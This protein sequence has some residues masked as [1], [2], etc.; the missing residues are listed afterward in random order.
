MQ[1]QFA[2]KQ[3]KYPVDEAC[4]LIRRVLDEI[5]KQEP[6][7]QKITRKGLECSLSVTFV[8]KVSMR[9]LNAETRGI[10]H[11][12]D[13]LSFPMLEMVDGRLKNQLQASDLDHSSG[14]PL[15]F[16]GDIV[17]C[18]EKAEQQAHQLGHS[19]ERE[20]AFLA[21]HGFLHLLGYDHD[22]PSREQKMLRRQRTALD[23]LGLTREYTPS[24]T[25]KES[26]HV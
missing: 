24:D 3:R 18:L 16:L 10:D 5:H 14:Q 20:M 22:I 25:Q 12:T 21:V 19:Y 11:V 7:N 9:K 1:I 26:Q 2:N 6:F 15:V 17:I 23:Q 8:G 13:V 4:T